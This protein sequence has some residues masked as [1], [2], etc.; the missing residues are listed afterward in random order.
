M[1]LKFLVFLCACL[2]SFIFPKCELI[3]Q[4]SIK[5]ERI[6]FLVGYSFNS[7]KFLGKTENA[8][9]QVFAIGYQKEIKKYQNGKLLW[10]TADFV[11]YIYYYYPKK[12]E[13]NLLV[14]QRGFGVSPVGFLLSESNPKRL[15]PFIKTS[16]GFIYMQS[17][18]PTDDSRQL[19]FNFDITLGADLKFDSVGIVSFGYKFHHIS[20]AE[21]GNENPGVDSNFIFIKLSI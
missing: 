10:Y 3:A 1:K 12:D 4:E 15:S 14:S 7:V 9:T 16:G 19:N 11:P 6:N 21:T 20:N 5:K 13:E 18:F 8:E 2:I 17:E